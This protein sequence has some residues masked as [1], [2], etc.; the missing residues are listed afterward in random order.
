MSI[1]DNLMYDRCAEHPFSRFGLLRGKVIDGHAEKAVSEFD[2]RPR[3]PKRIL[4]NLSGGNQQK[5]VLARVLAGRTTIVIASEPSRG[6]DFAATEFV[7]SQLVKA[8]EK[9][10]GVLLI[11]SDLDELLGLSHRLLV[12]F[13][14]KVAGELPRGQFDVN[15]IGLLMAGQTEAA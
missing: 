7:R 12:M 8:A 11:S 1:A 15:R 2:V 13:R 6:L 14:G 5:V 3:D 9:G 10:V 4:G